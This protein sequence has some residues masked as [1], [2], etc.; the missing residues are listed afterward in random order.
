MT[1]DHHH[2]SAPR[3]PRCDAPV[4]GMDLSRHIAAIERDLQARFGKFWWELETD[5]KSGWVY[6]SASYIL[7]RL[8]H[9]S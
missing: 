7:A 2:S 4:V 3:D 8:V 9:V 1:K 6:D 5:L